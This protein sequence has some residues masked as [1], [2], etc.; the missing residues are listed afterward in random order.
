ML[1]F[2][3]AGFQAIGAYAAAVLSIEFGL[4]IW[5]TVALATLTGGLIGFLIAPG[6]GVGP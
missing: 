6:L 4:G 3:G 5:Q 1:G 2:G